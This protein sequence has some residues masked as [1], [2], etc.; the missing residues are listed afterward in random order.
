MQVASS[1]M[2]LGASHSASQSQITRSIRH[3]DAPGDDAT[4]RQ[5]RPP[6]QNIRQASSPPLVATAQQPAA[7]TL[8][9]LISLAKSILEYMFGIHFSLIDGKLIPESQA[10]SGQTSSAQPQ[11]AQAAAETGTLETTTTYQESEQTHFSASGSVTTASGQ[12]MNFSLDVTM[13][14]SYSSTT[15]RVSRYGPGTDPL[16]ITLGTDAGTLSGATVSFDL[17]GDGTQV[18][19]PFARSGGWLALDK[20]GN[21]KIDNGQELFGPQSGNG[22]SDLATLDS[23]H[24]GVIDARDP[25]YADL[26]VWSGVD[27]KGQDQLASLQSMHIGALFLANVDTPFTIKDDSNTAQAQVRRSGVYLQEDGQAGM[28]SQVDVLA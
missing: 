22:F 25:A 20:N 14:R 7:N 4:R 18:N 24:D 17:K 21:G 3:A 26:R 12:T 15:S 19:L 9:P 6:A 5:P 27:S 23:N 2:N 11:P 16:M 13:Q 10:D 8:P 28:I 1:S